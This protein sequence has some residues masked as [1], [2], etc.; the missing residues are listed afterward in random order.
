MASE[1]HPAAGG[2]GE[3]T[4]QEMSGE[5]QPDGVTQLDASV[6]TQESLRTRVEDLIA[7]KSDALLED[8][9]AGRCTSYKV[10][11]SS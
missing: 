10:T 6:I 3:Q 2:R 11:R 7:V 8:W 9:N 1:D 4:L 5:A